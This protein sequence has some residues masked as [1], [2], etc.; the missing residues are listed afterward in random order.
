MAPLAELDIEQELSD[1]GFVNIS[2]QPFEEAA[3]ALDNNR[4]WRFPWTVISAEK[5][6]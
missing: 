4:A 5:P 2:I 1:A 3:G 6:A